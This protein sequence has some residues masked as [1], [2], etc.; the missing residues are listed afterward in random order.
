VTSSN[1][2]T[3][4]VQ[5]LQAAGCVAA[6]EEAIDLMAAANG[7]GARLRALVARRCQG[8]PI[9]WLLGS[10]T[11]CGETVLIHHGVYVPRWQSE[12][13]ALEAVDRLPE[14]GTA[15][16]LCTG[17]GALAVVLAR[18]RPDARVLA[19][20]TDPVAIACA[21]ANGVDVRTCDVAEGLP[22]ELLGRVDVVTA[23]VPYVP[24]GDL[25][26]LPRDVLAFEPRQALDGGPEGID[27]LVRTIRQVAPLLSPGGSLLLEVGGRQPERLQST[28]DACGYDDSRASFDQDGDV[29]GL[30]CRRAISAT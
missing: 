13:M 29:R 8:E 3:D 6:E 17:S 27:F 22:D 23:V 20:E 5:R 1:D 9:A 19:T 14:S 4:V 18:R 30:Y 7:D 15:I 12:P 25:Q 24:T 16:D 26:H 28:L 2:L 10:V 11:F 21:Q